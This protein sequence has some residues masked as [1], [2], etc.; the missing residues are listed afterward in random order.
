MPLTLPRWLGGRRRPLVTPIIVQVIHFICEQDGSPERD[1]KA[2][3]RPLLIAS[4]EVRVAYLVR[5]TYGD[6]KTEHVLLALRSTGPLDADLAFSL[7]APFADE[8]N[9][10]TSL[11]IAHV[12][13]DQESRIVQVCSPFYVAT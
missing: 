2:Q 12:S 11:D 7:R 10:E 9:R 5:V 4:P 3:W 13:A 6:D 8:F 1:L